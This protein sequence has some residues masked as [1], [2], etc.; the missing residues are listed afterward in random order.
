VWSLNRASDPDQGIWSW[1]LENATKIEALDDFTVAITLENASA[2]FLA[3][4]AMFNASVL[5]QAAIEEVGVDEF[6]KKPIGTGPFMVTEFLLN[7]YIMFEKN[8]YYWDLGAD[9]KPL[10]YLDGVLVIE[11]ADATTAVLQV[12]S[13]DMDATSNVPYAMMDNLQA[14]P[15]VQLKEF[16]STQSFYVYLNHLI[17]PMDDVKVRQAMNYAIDKDAMIDSVALGRGV[18]AT[19]FRPPGS[20]CYNDDLKGFPYDVEKAKQL[21]AESGYPDGFEGLKIQTSNSRGASHGELLVQMWAEIG[22]EAEVETL[23]GSLLSDLYWENTYDALAGWQWTDDVLDPHQHVMYAAVSP[24]MRTGFD[25]ERVNEL[26]AAA[27]IELDEEKRCEMYKEIQKIWNEEAVSILLYHPKF[28][29][30]LRND[31]RG[32]NQIPLGW[33]IWRGTWLDR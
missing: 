25:N 29:A 4:I 17:P 23:E 31:V 18:E 21:M 32:Y 33:L 15:N 6:F 27:A 24:A 7:D 19:S 9:G 14:D 28:Y 20:R 26:A 13:G 2:Q 12:Q 30:L 10:P 1:S 8:P 11:G 3:M 16:P 22:I 5:P